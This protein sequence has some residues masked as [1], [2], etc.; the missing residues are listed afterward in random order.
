MQSAAACTAFCYRAASPP[1]R[2][3]TGLE[4]GVQGAG[5]LR[6]CDLR[7]D[8]DALPQAA[9]GQELALG[10]L[11][12]HQGPDAAHRV[13]TIATAPQPNHVS[14]YGCTPACPQCALAD[15]LTDLVQGNDPIHPDYEPSLFADDFEPAGRASA[16]T[17]A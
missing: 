3:V 6:K 11:V 10:V 5:I 13:R 12:R 2:C 8:V 7:I 15:L 17:H 14:S 1:R 4:F 9:P 16:A